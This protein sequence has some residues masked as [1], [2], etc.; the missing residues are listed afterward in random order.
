MR[1]M[2]DGPIPGENY[3]SDTKNYPWHRPPE[4]TKYDDA[5]KY[6]I[7]KLTDP[8]AAEGLLTFIEAGMPIATAADIFVTNG[9][10]K[11]KWTP[12]FAI[13]IAGPVA[14][15]M[16][17]MAKAAEIEYDLG[18]DDDV[19]VPTVEF[20]KAV[21]EGNIDKEQVEDASE[22]IEGS[23]DDF[24]EEPMGVATG[25]LMAPQNEATGLTEGVAP[26]DEQDAMLGYDPTDEEEV[27]V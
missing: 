1:N 5:I 19:P 3:T 24:S 7:E 18:I 21:A 6:S 26:M 27:L 4:L 9:I 15:M 16:E 2:L 22:A 12:D 25:G 10:G 17:L 23:V 11:G 20:F 8:K 14:R 13:L